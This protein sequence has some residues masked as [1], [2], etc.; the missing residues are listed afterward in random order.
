M[1]N[2]SQVKAGD[3]IAFE[4]FDRR[5]ASCYA[6]RC[7]DVYE[8]IYNNGDYLVV[9]GYRVNSAGQPCGKRARVSVLASRFNG[10][11]GPRP[12]DAFEQIASR[13]AEV[14]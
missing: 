11:Q 6:E 5:V 13:Y 4:K 7:F 3:R 2:T 8:V 10:V 9:D 1:K 14:Q 12:L